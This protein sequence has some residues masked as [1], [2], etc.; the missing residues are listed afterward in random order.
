MKSP[1]WIWF[2]FKA[3]A[4]AQTNSAESFRG[5]SGRLWWVGPAASGASGDFERSPSCIHLVLVFNQDSSA[6]D[7][8][9]LNPLVSHRRVGER[10][11][12]IQTRSTLTSTNRKNL[13]VRR[14][15]GSIAHRTGCRRRGSI[16]WNKTP[17]YNMTMK[18]EMNTCSRFDLSNNPKSVWDPQLIFNMK[19]FSI[20][21][22]VSDVEF[23]QLM[24]FIFLIESSVCVTETQK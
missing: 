3:A 10:C 17:L 2:M 16:P 5:T 12:R 24:S 7:V 23:K 9:S 14:P 4:A 13:G 15:V 8:S 1:D 11:S 6:G 22:K 18:R 20:F 21:N 19:L